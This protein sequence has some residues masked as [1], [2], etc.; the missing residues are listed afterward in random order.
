M[1]EITDTERLDWVLKYGSSLRFS[2]D[3]IWFVAHHGEAINSDRIAMAK[4]HIDRCI[5]YERTA[6]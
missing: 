4:A 2:G 3:E 6:A 1:R 5:R